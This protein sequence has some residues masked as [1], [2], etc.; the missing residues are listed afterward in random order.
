MIRGEASKVNFKMVS[1]IDYTPLSGLTVTTHL[2]V[3]GGAFGATT[4]SAVE[5]GDGWYYVELTALETDYSEVVLK[6]S[7]TGAAQSDGVLTPQSPTSIS[8]TINNN[9]GG[10]GGA[11]LMY[12]STCAWM[13]KDIKAVRDYFT[14]YSEHIGKINEDRE[15]MMLVHTTLTEFINRY[16]TEQQQVASDV[17]MVRESLEKLEELV[18]KIIPI[19]QLEEFG[20]GIN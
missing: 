20:N 11:A 14:K 18:L 7:A 17:S 15:P 12:A 10:V 1:S 3:D 6:A 16:N 9:G 13:D 19:E 4:N 2:S 8:N 5:I